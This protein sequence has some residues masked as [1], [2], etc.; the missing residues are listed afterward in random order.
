LFLSL[1]RRGAFAGPRKSVSAS[2]IAASIHGKNT[3][4][5]AEIGKNGCLAG[6]KR[7]LHALNEE[8]QPF[9]EREQGKGFETN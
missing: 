2:R 4:Q 3:R 5:V 9:T 8:K 1:Q 7:R 6:E